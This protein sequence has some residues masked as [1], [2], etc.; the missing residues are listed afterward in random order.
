MFY[1]DIGDYLKRVEKFYIIK[2]FAD[3]SGIIWEEITPNDSYDW[4]NQRNDIFESFTSLGDKKDKNSQTIFDVYSN[5]VKTNRDAWVYNFSQESVTSNMTRMIDFY[6][7]QLEEFRKH[8]KELDITNS[9]E[10]KKAVEKFIDTDSK[11]ISWSRE[12]KYHVGRD[13]EHSFK[14]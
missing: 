1:H 7:Q 10:R 3:I 4:I 11:K 8:L 12:L 6:N 14:S 2:N 5:G 9:E 13:I